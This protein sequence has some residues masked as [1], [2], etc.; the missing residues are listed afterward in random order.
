MRNKVI[1]STLL[2]L[3]IALVFTSGVFAA[4]L[5]AKD[6]GF[7]SRNEEW[8]VDNVEDAMNDLYDIG[9]YE[10]TP[11]TY[12]YDSSTSEED[13][14]R[15]KK[16]DGKYY[17]CDQNGN[18]TSEE[19][20]DVSSIDLVEYTM[21]SNDSLVLGKAGF[22]NEQFILGNASL[23]NNFEIV[24]VVNNAS[25]ATYQY[26]LTKDY[27]NILIFASSNNRSE[28]GDASTSYTCKVNHD[29]VTTNYTNNTDNKILVSNSGPAYN[30][31]GCGSWILHDLKE[32]DTITIGVTGSN[33][34]III[35]A[36]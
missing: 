23:G 15:Y 20:K 29:G 14:V 7:T 33:R 4:K 34:K 35:V 6:I 24:K 22:S 8:K 25:S 18:I 30:P 31:G 16:I 10:I 27:R 9:K 17:L 5:S 28:S 19:E 32:N 36:F 1:K 3:G 2:I 11:D 13:I 21:A 26:K 12:F